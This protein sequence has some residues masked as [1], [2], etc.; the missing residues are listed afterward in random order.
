MSRED[1][2]REFYSIIGNLGARWDVA[3]TL[4]DFLLAAPTQHGASESAVLYVIN[5][6][7]V[8]GPPEGSE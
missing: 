1:T 2:N 5:K 4:N 8:D 7:W 6:L 3:R